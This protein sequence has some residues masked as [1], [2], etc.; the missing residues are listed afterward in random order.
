MGFYEKS[1]NSVELPTLQKCDKLI[2]LFRIARAIQY[3][4]SKGIR[5]NKIEL[6]NI[7]YL[8]KNVELGLPSWNIVKEKNNNTRKVHISAFMEIFTHFFP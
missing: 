8:N 3:L 5:H 2:I 7:F 4:E 1:L 6:G